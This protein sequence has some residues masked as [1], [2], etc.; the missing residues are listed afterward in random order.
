MLQTGAGTIT[1]CDIEKNIPA[2]ERKLHSVLHSVQKG[3]VQNENAK[4]GWIVI[5]RRDMMARVIHRL[6]H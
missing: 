1:Q 3:L 5:H 4:S 6:T 2:H